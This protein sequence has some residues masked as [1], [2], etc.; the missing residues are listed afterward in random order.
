MSAAAA[1]AILAPLG[2][3][4]LPVKG[5]GNCLFRALGYYFYGTEMMHCKTRTLLSDFV[6]ANSNRFKSIVMDGDVMNHAQKMQ[7]LSVWGTHVELQATASLFQVP[8]YMLTFSRQQNRY[9]WHCYQPWDSSKLKFPETEPPPTH[10]SNLDHVELLHVR[11]CHFDVILH[12]EE[13]FPLDRP[14]LEAARLFIKLE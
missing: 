8:V 3:K 11:A 4:V 10:I 1:E 5:D 13:G 2:R 12:E 14:V 7:H 6:V 9:I